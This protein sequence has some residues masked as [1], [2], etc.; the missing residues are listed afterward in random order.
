MQS[1]SYHPGTFAT[2]APAPVKTAARAH[3]AELYAATDELGL[4]EDLGKG[5]CKST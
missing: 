3:H 2:A 5:Q 1:C 4:D